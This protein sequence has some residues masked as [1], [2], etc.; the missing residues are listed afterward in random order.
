MTTL[1]EFLDSWTSDNIKNYVDLLG[2]NSSITRKADRIAFVC[3]KML[4]KDSLNA[5]WNTLDHISQRAV[6]TAYHNGGRFNKAAFVNQY[7]EL[8]PRPKNDHSW[9]YY[10][11]RPILFDLFVVNEEISE[12]LMPL[13]EDLILPVE[14]FQI[15]GIADAPVAVK[16]GTFTT[17]VTTVETEFI[18]RTDLMTYLQLV[19]LGKVNFSATSRRL[20]AA[21]VRK[22]L[23]T[24]LD[25][26][27]RSVPEKVTGRTVIRPFGLDVFTQ[28]S[29]LVTHTGKLTKAGRDYLKTQD[30]DILLQ[31]FEKWTDSGQFDELNRI[32]A[33]SGVNAKRT[34]LT[35]PAYRREKVI[36]ALS[37]C[38]VDTWI[39]INDFYRG[40]IIW[41]FDF[42][43]EQTYDFNLYIGSRYYGE[44]YG[45]SYWNVVHGL[46][47]NIIIWEYL[48]T[49][50]AVDIGYVEDEDISLVNRD[51]DIDGP[52]SLCDGLVCFRINKWGAFLLGQAMAYTPEQPRQKDLFSIDD[53]YQV[54]VLNLL[55]P[56]EQLQLDAIAEHIDEQLYQLDSFKLLTAVESGQTLEQI[57]SFLE[58]SHQGNLP[59]SVGEWLAQLNRNQRAFKTVG[60]AML[61]Q[62]K[63]PELAQ[64]IAG[65]EELSKLCRILDNDTILVRTSRLTRFQKRLKVLGYLFK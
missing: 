11:N 64:V 49:L 19:D 17:P 56:A 37:W 45:Q 16:S 26:D 32:T 61:I 57:I 14:R 51:Y 58:A 40:L 38:P 35:E 46:Y 42:E 28:E 33:L 63:Y 6:S 9:G 30:P 50:G 15:E 21:S 43:V 1:R 48:A 47:I 27:F 60:E 8:P 10:Y 3:D 25:G 4:D 2:G 18:G 59:S 53:T 7:G 44:L 24:L 62:L 54:H 55:Q 31:A 65:D 5:I 34:H 13:L 22:V 12:D 36:E 23:D 39:S 52:L 41:D 20:T 29:G